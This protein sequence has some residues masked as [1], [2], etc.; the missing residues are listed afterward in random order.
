M[1]AFSISARKFYFEKFLPLEV[2]QYTDKS[3]L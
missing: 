1:L 2:T 3:I